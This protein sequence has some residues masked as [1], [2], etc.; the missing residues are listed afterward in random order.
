MPSL[1]INDQNIELRY[2]D[3]GA[4]PKT[5][6]T[7]YI[8]LFMVHGM[9]FTGPIFK[10]IQA[11]AH[12]SNL[13]V[14]AMNRRGYAGSTPLTQAEANAPVVGSDEQKAAYL[15]DRGIEIANFVDS[16]IQK[17]DLPHITAD[18]KGGGVG[19]LGWSS[20]SVSALSAVAWVDRLPSD[21]QRRLAL[22][23]RSLILQEPPSI[24]LGMPIPPGTWMPRIDPSIPEKLQLSMFVQWGTSYFDHG[25]LATRDPNVL[26]YIVPSVSRRPSIYAMSDEDRQDFMEDV[27]ESKIMVSVTSQS[28]AMFRKACFDPDVRARLPELKIWTLAGD[29]T[30]SF[31][32]AS[33]WTIQDEDKERGSGFVNY[34]MIP[35]ANHYV[36]WDDPE[37]AVQAYIEALA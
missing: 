5:S 6:S 13:R 10:K 26:S 15:A 16:F 17:H 1:I 32:I 8:T 2:T 19:L 9:G 31:A 33:F 7:P 37:K 35:G 28:L 14:V 23:M 21:T 30:V 24:S 12:S 36:H 34:K 27:S 22:C 18:R 29:A 11:L 3:S 4:P 20:G 25:D